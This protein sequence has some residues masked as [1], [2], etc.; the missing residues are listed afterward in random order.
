[1]PFT[2]HE[3]HPDTGN[4]FI[5]YHVQTWA[6]QKGYNLT[7]SEPYKKNDNMCIEERNHTI[8]RTEVGYAR[9]DDPALVPL[10]SE[11][12]KVACTYRNHFR[13]VRRMTSKVR[14]G[15]RWKRVFE[16]VAQTPYARV[17]RQKDVP[18]EVK[19]KLRA[20]HEKLNPVVLK[21]K[22]DTLKKGLRKKLRA[23]RIMK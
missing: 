4:E 20:E 18:E 13:P 11:I 17:L 8:P 22:L 12:L 10:V 9:I 6:K 23:R 14:V 21:R 16:K 19:A 15:A 7:R 1:M 3:V 5:N 2:V